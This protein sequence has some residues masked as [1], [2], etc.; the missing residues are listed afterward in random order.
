VA[1]AVSWLNPHIGQ[2]YVDRRVIAETAARLA[3]QNPPETLV[4]LEGVNN[5]LLRSGDTSTVGYRVVLD[6]WKNKEG[7]QTVETWLKA[8]ASHP[9]YD[10]LAWQY[11]ALVTGE[12]PNK[13]IQWANTIKRPA[14]KQEVLRAIGNRPAKGKS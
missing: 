10:H 11:A 5:T 3:R 8:Q 4:W 1:D 9:H 7:A 13:A 14:I 2:A 6:A 12:E